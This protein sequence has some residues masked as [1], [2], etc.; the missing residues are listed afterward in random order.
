[1]TVLL[2]PIDSIPDTSRGPLIGRLEIDQHVITKV[3]SDS[4]RSIVRSRDV[5]IV[6][7]RVFDIT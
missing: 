5:Y 1:M 7:E 6:D 3:H 4:S 2:I